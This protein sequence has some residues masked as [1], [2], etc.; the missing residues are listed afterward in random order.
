MRHVALFIKRLCTL[1]NMRLSSSQD[2]TVV[3]LSA[4]Y[5]G[6]IN[7]RKPLPSTKHSGSQSWQS[8]QW[9]T[10]LCFLMSRHRLWVGVANVVTLVS[11][12]RLVV[13]CSPCRFTSRCLSWMWF[14]IAPVKWLCELLPTQPTHNL[15]ITF[16]FVKI[17]PNRAKFP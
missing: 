16:F 9:W 10:A 17:L 5:S 6:C 13:A 4:V 7:L 12:V 2:I 14:L 3:L 1:E 15:V 11:R 8:F